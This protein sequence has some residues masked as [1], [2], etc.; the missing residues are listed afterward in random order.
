[1]L[2]LQFHLTKSN[3]LIGHIHSHYSGRVPFQASKV[4]MGKPEP[5]SASR[6]I[7]LSLLFNVGR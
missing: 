3:S 2:A 7:L 1:M 5:C 4:S 6:G